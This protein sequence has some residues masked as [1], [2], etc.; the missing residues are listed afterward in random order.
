MIGA[1]L[2]FREGQ[3]QYCAQ[4]AQCLLSFTDLAPRIPSPVYV[5]RQVEQ[6]GYGLGSIQVVIHCRHESMSMGFTLHLRAGTRPRSQCVTDSFQTPF[7]CSRTLFTV[8]QRTAVVAAEE[9]Q[10]HGIRMESFQRVYDR[11]QIPQ[12]FAHLVRAQLQQSVVHPIP[13]K[14]L[15]ARVTFALGDLVFV[16]WKYQVL[17]APVDVQ[18]FPQ[19]FQ[20]HRRTFDVPAGP[21]GSPRA[22][23]G[24]LA[25]LGSLPQHKVHGVLFVFVNLN[26][27]AGYHAVQRPV[28]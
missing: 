19:V 14:G 27:G 16:V 9:I 10:A 7:D 20:R 3:P 5:P 26:A 22:G 8:R 13:G 4:I 12:R 23:P 28:A 21:P 6:C 1:V 18:L 25:F 17:T 15:G 11:H 2:N 24:R